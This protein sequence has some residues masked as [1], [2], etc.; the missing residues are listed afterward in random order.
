[1]KILCAILV[2]FALILH[3]F[4]S[5]FFDTKKLSVAVPLMLLAGVA[6]VAGVK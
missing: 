2:N 4:A 5:H 6:G 3:A 1:L